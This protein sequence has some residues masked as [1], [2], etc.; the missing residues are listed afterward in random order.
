MKSE[1]VVR[2][3]DTSINDVKIIGE[4]IQTLS[5]V[6][7]SCFQENIYRIDLIFWH[8]PFLVFP[9][10]VSMLDHGFISNC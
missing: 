6:I 8:W 4:T 3:F 9:S 5:I 2:F 10:I 7:K 1:K